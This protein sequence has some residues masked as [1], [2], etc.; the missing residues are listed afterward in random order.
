MDEKQSQEL[1]K[2]L[3]E[4][5]N[6]DYTKFRTQGI[7]IGWY[8]AHLS[9]LDHIKTLRYKR[10]IVAYLEAEIKRIED[11]L[12]LPEIPPENTEF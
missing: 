1:Q 3:E 5:L 9:M 2:I 6:A 7:M 10:D 8:S 12:E 11:K 4:K